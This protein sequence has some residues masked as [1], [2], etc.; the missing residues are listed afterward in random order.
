MPADLSDF[1]DPRRNEIQA[2]IFSV[3]EE[4]NRPGIDDKVRKQTAKKVKSFTNTLF[5]PSN[6]HTPNFD[7]NAVLQ[8]K[9]TTLQNEIEIFNSIRHE[10][11]RQI[12]SFVLDTLEKN[13][14]NQ[15][16]FDEIN[17]LRE[18]RKLQ[19][20]MFDF[21]ML[22]NIVEASPP[23]RAHLEFYKRQGILDVSTA[24]IERQKAI[25]EKWS[26]SG[27]T[28]GLDSVMRDRL[29]RFI[30]EYPEFANFN[31]LDEVF[32]VYEYPARERPGGTKMGRDYEAS[33]QS[34]PLSPRP[35]SPELGTLSLSSGPSTSA[36]YYEPDLVD[37]DDAE[38]EIVEGFSNVDN[39]SKDSD[40][41]ISDIEDDTE[42]ATKKAKLEADGEYVKEKAEEAL[43]KSC[44]K[45][46]S[47]CSVKNKDKIVLDEDS[48]EL[49]ENKL[50]FEF[51]EPHNKDVKYTV[52]TE[53]D[54]RRLS[55]LKYIG[56]KEKYSKNSGKDR[57]IRGK[58]ETALGIHGLVMSVFGAINAFEQG[59]TVSGAITVAQTLH[60]LHSFGSVKKLSDFAT[61]ISKKGSSEGSHSWS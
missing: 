55:S 29:R 53:I 18:N 34:L 17:G 24:A 35:S 41:E 16:S 7:E 30:E 13:A 33:H 36:A 15:P 57:G 52:S 58:I 51:Y 45:R 21:M 6:T 8:Q 60:T 32:S 48:V 23:K 61:K 4:L 56:E 47:I 42:V 59:D 54:Q 28:L 19:G 44:E 22:T 40:T 37:S 26:P 31:N 49:K 9:L 14:A 38:S 12:A 5:N 20:I 39:L 27:I 3:Q 11:Q 43:T 25:D 10:E 2:A 50:N 46:E 1:H